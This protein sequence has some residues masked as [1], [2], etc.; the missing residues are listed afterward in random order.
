MW[1]YCTFYCLTCILKIRDNCLTWRYQRCRA[2][3]HFHAAVLPNLS[4]LSAKFVSLSLLHEK[5]TKK[6]LIK[7]VIMVDNWLQL[8]WKAIVAGYIMLIIVF[9]I[10]NYQHPDIWGFSGGRKFPGWNFSGEIIRVFHGWNY[11]RDLIRRLTAIERP[12]LP[13]INYYN[14]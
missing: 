12:Q 2:L 6:K 9:W 7:K 3:Y 8:H 11:Q 10:L 13:K 1:K 5:K 14:T 4:K